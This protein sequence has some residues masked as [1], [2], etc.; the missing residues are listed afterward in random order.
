L[1]PKRLANDRIEF[2]GYKI[3]LAET[4]VDSGRFVGTVYRASN[5][6]LVGNTRSFKRKDNGYDKENRTSK[7]VFIKP[8][9]KDAKRILS[10]PLL[11]NNY[12][13]AEGK[14]KIKAERMYSLPDLF[15]LISDPRRGQGKRHSLQTVL[16]IVTGAIICGMRGYKAISDWAASLR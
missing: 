4:V 14:M 5:W 15:K 1:T 16:A 6:Q 9:R 3:V 13:G 7:L 8:L 11:K 10:Q 12:Q 2:F